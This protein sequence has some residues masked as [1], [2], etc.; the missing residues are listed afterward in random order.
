MAKYH[1]Y[2]K[3]KKD[4]LK[5]YHL[6]KTEIHNRGFKVPEGLEPEGEYWNKQGWII[7]YDIRKCEKRKVMDEE[8]KKRTLEKR[9]E[10]L[11]INRTCE[12]CNYEQDQKI[13]E[14]KDNKRICYD[15]LEK[16]QLEEEKQIE[17][18]NFQQA[19]EHSFR[20]KGIPFEES[21]KRL[22]LKIQEEIEKDN[23]IEL[24]LEREPANTYDENA[25][26]IMCFNEQ[27]GYVD[28]RVASKVA[29]ILDNSSHKISIEF[30]YDDFEIYNYDYY[31]DWDNE[32]SIEVRTSYNL[33]AIIKIK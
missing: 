8:T 27:L 6:S 14:Y 26:K 23:K 21:R 11:R 22:A 4:D 33:N 18:L 30:D 9:K 2:E 12:F 19:K 1:G 24:S 3:L 20:I 10:T 29:P 28:A 15:C 5:E 7:V 13:V 31:N 32:D 17:E 25:I 16:I